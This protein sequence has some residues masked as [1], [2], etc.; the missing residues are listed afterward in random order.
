MGPSYAREAPRPI[1]IDEIHELTRQFGDAAVRMQKIVIVGGG[2]VGCETADYL[3]PL[4]N[5]LA[6]SNRDV[7]LIEMTR[8]LAANEGG[9]GRAVLVTRI[10]D[11]GVHVLTEAK[12]TGV[13][14]DTISYEKDGEEHVIEGADTLVLALGYRPNTALA[15]ALTEAGFACHV[16]GDSKQCGNLRDAIEAGY[17]AAC[18]L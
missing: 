17:K 1:T 3:A 16:L 7:T 14:E 5:D 13:T 8:T 6:P 12:L 15:D 4:V 10:L 9:A 2:S 11:K 18:E